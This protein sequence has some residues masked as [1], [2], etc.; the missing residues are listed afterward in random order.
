MNAFPSIA[1]FTLAHAAHTGTGHTEY[2]NRE[3]YAGR[4]IVGGIATV[5]IPSDA[6]GF[7]ELVLRSALDLLGSDDARKAETVGVWNHDGNTY[8]DLGDTY[9]LIEVALTIARKRGELAIWDRVTGT[10]IGISL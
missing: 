6:A 9:Y 1:A 5:V 3:E 2:R 7:P 10:E 4:Y 8:L